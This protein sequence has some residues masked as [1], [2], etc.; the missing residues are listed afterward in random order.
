MAPFNN[1]KTEKNERSLSA[2]FEKSLVTA[3]F[4]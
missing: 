2:V 3:A 4:K 1:N